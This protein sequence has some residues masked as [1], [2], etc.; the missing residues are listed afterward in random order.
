MYV[1][2]TT[3]RNEMLENMMSKRPVFESDCQ[4][5]LIEVCVKQLVLLLPLLKQMGGDCTSGDCHG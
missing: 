5:Y 3:K 2:G 4:W 1:V